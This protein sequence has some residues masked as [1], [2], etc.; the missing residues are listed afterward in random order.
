LLATIKSNVT[1]Q[2]FALLNHI[3]EIML[4]TVNWYDCPSIFVISVS[5]LIL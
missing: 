5:L 3:Q 2:L 4:S 1:V